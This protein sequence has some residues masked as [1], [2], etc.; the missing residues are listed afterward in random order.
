MGSSSL[1]RDWTWA[2]YIGSLESLPLEHQESSP[3]FF[4]TSLHP[5]SSRCWFPS[6]CVSLCFAL[7]VSTFRALCIE[8]KH[9]HYSQFA[10]S[11]SAATLIAL[12]PERRLP[13]PSPRFETPFLERH[14]AAIKGPFTCTHVHLT[15][16]LGIQV[17]KHNVTWCMVFEKGSLFSFTFVNTPGG[18]K[19]WMFYDP[20]KKW[21]NSII[22]LTKV[23][24]IVCLISAWAPWPITSN[25]YTFKTSFLALHWYVG[26][27]P[28]APPGKPK[29]EC[30]CL[31]LFL[32]A[33]LQKPKP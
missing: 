4:I 30:I 33:V 5:L 13:P 26:S 7:W 11:S 2:P 28:L 24:Q 3:N 17:Q 10:R 31:Q 22:N 12:G 29:P 20:W 18:M 19:A 1:T 16:V 27:L 32:T 9:M 14:R 6:T 8:Y 15:P 25:S 23:T 21:S